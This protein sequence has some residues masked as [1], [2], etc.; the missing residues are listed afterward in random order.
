MDMQD[1]LGALT[2]IIAEEDS[3]TDA[4]TAEIDH[5][6]TSRFAGVTMWK[7]WRQFHRVTFAKWLVEFMFSFPFLPFP[8]PHCGE[9]P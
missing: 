2:G 6:S 1:L 7:V 4:A 8:S 9:T 5:L 3:M